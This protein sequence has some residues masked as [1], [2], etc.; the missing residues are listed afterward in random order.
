MGQEGV[1]PKTKG[2]EK[3]KDNNNKSNGRTAVSFEVQTSN[4]LMMGK[5]DQ[6]MFC[7]QSFNNF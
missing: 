6:N 4:H 7:V 3:Q 1:L 2:D 5:L